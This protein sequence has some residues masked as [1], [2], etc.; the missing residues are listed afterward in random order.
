MASI[1]TENPS[2]R[3]FTPTAARAWTPFSPNTFF[4][5]SEQPFMTK[6]CWVKSIVQLTNPVSFT[7]CVTLF[8]SP[9]SFFRAAN[10]ARP[11]FCA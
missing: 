3:E 2:G 4:I 1:S 7:N 9:I 11:H 6:G 10:I 8:K 5:R